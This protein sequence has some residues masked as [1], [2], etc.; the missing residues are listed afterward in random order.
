VNNRELEN[1]IVKHDFGKKNKSLINK[2]TS[3]GLFRIDLVSNTKRNG[4]KLVILPLR[5]IV[6]SNLLSYLK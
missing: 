1:L 5:L 3:P 6:I 2:I 4:Y